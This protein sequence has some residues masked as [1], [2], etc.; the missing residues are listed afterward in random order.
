MNFDGCL[1]NLIKDT[2]A[3]EEYK[4]FVLAGLKNP[5]DEKIIAELRTIVEKYEDAI[6]NAEDNLRE[7]KA[8]ILKNA[9]KEVSKAKK[10]RKANVAQSAPGAATPAQPAADNSAAASAQPAADNSAAADEAKQTLQKIINRQDNPVGTKRKANALLSALEENKEN[11]LT[12]ANKFLREVPATMYQTIVPEAGHDLIYKAFNDWVQ[13]YERTNNTKL[14]PVPAYKGRDFGD[15]EKTLLARGDIGAVLDRL[16]AAEK[17]PAI[18]QVLRKLRSLGLKSKVEIASGNQG[19]FDPDN[20]DILRQPARG[21]YD[22]ATDTI[23]LDPELGLNTHTFLHEVVH[24]AIS[25]VINNRSAPLTKEFEKFFVSIKGRLGSSYGGQ[26]M[27]EF[28]AELLSNP[29]F[30]AILKDIKTP[31]SE[32][33]F[34]RVMRAIAEFFGFPPKS[35][36]FTSGLDFVSQLIDVSQ[37]TPPSPMEKLFLTTGS[38]SV[39]TSIGKAMPALTGQAIE[40]TRNTLSNL[41]ESG[42]LKA[43]LGL[44][45]MDNLYTLYKNELPQIKDVMDA[46]EQRQGSLEKQIADVQKKYQGMRATVRKKPEQV[47]RLSEL[48]INARLEEVDILNPTFV[49]SAEKRSAY[50]KLKSQFAALDSDVQNIYRVARKDYDAMFNRHRKLLEDAVEASQSPSLAAKLRDQF[51]KEIPSVA[52][53]PFLR[54]GDFWVSYTDPETNAPAAFAFES[55]REREQFVKMLNDKNIEHKTYQKIED[56]RFTGENIPQSSFIYQVMQKLRAQKADPAHLDA[57]WQSYLATFPSGS[58]MKQFM[59]SRNVAGM[60]KDIVGGYSDIMVRWARKLANA[61]Y[62]PKLD[63]ALAD[64]KAIGESAKDPVVTAVAS[65]IIQQASFLH[66]PSFNALTTTATTASY[67]M[68]MAGNISSALINMLSLPMMVW[69]K[70]VGDFNWENATRVSLAA[71]RTAMGN[72]ADNARYKKLHE[73]L[74]DHAQLEH[75][76]SREILE[77]RRQKTEDYLGIKA[78]IL[79]GLSL[80]IAAAEKYNRA[81]TAIAAYDLKRNAGASETDAIAYA[82]QTVKDIHTSGMAATG[83]LWMQNSIGRVFFTFKSFVWNAAFVTARAFHQSFKG[84]SPEVRSA[85][86]RQLL[87][88]YGMAFAFT[89]LRGMPFYG[90]FSLLA[91]ML[92]ALFG[93]EDDPFDIDEF[94]RS[95]TND[96]IFKG[97]AN[98]FLNLEVATRAGIANDLLYRDDPR[99]IAEHGYTM[100]ALMQALGPAGSLLLN[101][102]RGAEQFQNGNIWRS[103]E[104]ISPSW[105]RNGLKGARFMVEG[106]TTLDGDPVMQDISAYNSLM[107][108]IGFAPADLSNTYETLQA[109]KGYERELLARR[110]KLLDLYDMAREAGDTDMQSMAQERIS[111]FND[112]N[113]ALRIT[114]DTLNRSMRARRAAEAEM[115]RGVR[116]NKKL[117]PLIEE[118]F[119]SEDEE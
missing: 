16:S 54:S 112:T 104:T 26:D 61:E 58:I 25:K 119:F 23:Y 13:E 69:P 115:I 59:K 29:R 98:Y 66:N 116:F 93:D 6:K 27:Q 80:P 32:T 33:L 71:G 84:D 109:A 85:A 70:L 15:V 2:A 9:Q 81:A 118:R 107:Q 14:L 30:Q 74:N 51:T 40:S 65:N 73:T 52:Y 46:V 1:K 87:A 43:A 67:F 19:T 108:V 101:L 68:F 50:N 37:N 53:V 5:T 113:P 10:A 22:P 44:L 82:L 110:T 72:W 92:D 18:Q 38:D 96:F 35:T 24:A 4:S 20:P 117:R 36:A 83:P 8:R 111:K 75:T 76:M 99:F 94:L 106:A 64:I 34:Q 41:K 95:S 56:A 90:G 86:K 42:L 45:R 21:A 91:Q 55:V 49:P 100:F 11:A 7:A 78:R 63:K 48:A 105:V 103:V 79:D 60:N 31:Q 114:Q 17:N 47:R 62:G 28:A 77:G 97:P 12:D 39:I 102:E 89:G 3:R 88:M 57:V